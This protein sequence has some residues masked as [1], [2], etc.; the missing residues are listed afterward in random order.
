MNVTDQVEGSGIQA[1]ALI[2]TETEL[3]SLYHEHQGWLYGAALKYLRP[4]LQDDTP[5][6]VNE[7]LLALW[8]ARKRVECPIAFTYATVKQ[9]CFQRGRRLENR[10]A[11][12]PLTKVANRP[13]DELNPEEQMLEYEKEKQ[14][15][16]RREHIVSKLTP[17]EQ[18][19]YREWKAR[20][21]KANSH[22]EHCKA[23]R[24]RK[25]LTGLSKEY[26]Q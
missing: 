1:T 2:R 21:F 16:D 7:A 26:V 13:S 4:H 8:N 20:G 22:G 5:D 11:K 17:V 9:L 24:L 14:K 23:Y 18:N 3:E 25:R 6:V 19:N 12:T 10:T 15:I